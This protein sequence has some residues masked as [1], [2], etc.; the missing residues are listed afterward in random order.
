MRWAGHLAR[1]KAI[2]SPYEFLVGKSER[3]RS[4][5]RH[6]IRWEGN[7]KMDLNEIGWDGIDWIPIAQN[8]D[9][10]RALVNTVMNL[11]VP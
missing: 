9:K 6:M 4:F 5:R 7:I 11:R 1:K 10:W 2:R 8:W 3:N